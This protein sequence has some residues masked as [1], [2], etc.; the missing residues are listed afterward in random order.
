MTHTPPSAPPAAAQQFLQA[1]PMFIAIPQTH[2]QAPMMFYAAQQAA[3]PPPVGWP[4]NDVPLERSVAGKK[5][6]TCKCSET[7]S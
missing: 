2:Q 6:Q 5:I 3:P 4:A 7:S 1:M